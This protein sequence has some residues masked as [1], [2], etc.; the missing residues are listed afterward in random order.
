M[1]AL[2]QACGL[3]DDVQT[4][5]LCYFQALMG[6]GQQLSASDRL[7]VA[8][9]VKGAQGL[10]ICRL[11]TC[12]VVVPDSV[13]IGCSNE[14]C[15]YQGCFDCYTTMF[16]SAKAPAGSPFRLPTCPAC[17]APFPAATVTQ[18]LVDA[19]SD[20][21]SGALVFLCA[22]GEDCQCAAGHE[23][24]HVVPAQEQAA[25]TNNG[26]CGA[27]GAPVEARHPHLICAACEL[28][29]ETTRICPKCDQEWQHGGG[30]F[31]MTCVALK[32]D[33]EACGCEWCFHC[34]LAF[35]DVYA[36]MNEVIEELEE[37]GE[38]ADPTYWHL[39]LVPNAAKRGVE[40]LL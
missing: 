36:H 37:G 4:G 15:A 13:L 34:G 5:L 18:L 21:A 23:Q 28:Q 19:H 10:G 12:S 1:H 24:L 9:A 20:V 25:A 22:S 39:P 11:M 17:R 16:Q 26:P 7:E 31:H 2:L 14:Q 32:D 40:L 30:C 8:R 35:E 27:A 33:G 38:F 6:S 29:P 3:D